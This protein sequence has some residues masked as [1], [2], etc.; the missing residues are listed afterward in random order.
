MIKIFESTGRVA[1]TVRPNLAGLLLA[2]HEL[3]NSQGALGPFDSV[4]APPLTK[5]DKPCRG[6]VAAAIDRWVPLRIAAARAGCRWVPLGPVSA[7]ACVGRVARVSQVSRR[8]H[9]CR[10]VAG[11]TQASQLL[12]WSGRCGRRRSLLRCSSGWRWASRTA[13]PASKGIDCDFN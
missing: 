11:V 8:R 9:D 3:I 6:Q 12:G 2:S 13:D 7:A 1:R 10:G 5:P 4:K